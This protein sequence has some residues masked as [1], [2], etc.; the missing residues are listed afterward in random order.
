MKEKTLDEFLG[1]IYGAIDSNLPMQLP[2]DLSAE[3]FPDSEQYG[4]IS[5]VKTALWMY[6]LESAVGWDKIELA[7]HNY[8]NKWKNKHP[9]PEDLQAA[10]EE[11]IGGKLDKFFALT[12]K[13]GKFE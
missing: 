10:F 13:E 1:L 4:L 8:F 9:Q 12:K 5:Y 7:V 3:K 11:A 2:M 6:I